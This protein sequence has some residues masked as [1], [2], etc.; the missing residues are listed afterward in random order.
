MVG[1]AAT[2]RGGLGGSHRFC[3][4]NGCLQLKLETLLL[5]HGATEELEKGLTLEYLALPSP[6]SGRGG[7]VRFFL[8]ANKARRKATETAG[9]PSMNLPPGGLYGEAALVGGLGRQCE[10]E[11]RDRG[12]LTSRAAS[13]SLGG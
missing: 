10:G 1:P 2:T 12:H 6:I 3:L 7:V 11:V 4:C 5:Q 13:A 8:L 9:A